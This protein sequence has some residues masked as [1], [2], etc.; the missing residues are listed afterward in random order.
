MI[1]DIPKEISPIIKES[2]TAL[3]FISYHTFLSSRSPLLG[4]G[5]S[6]R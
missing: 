2:S 3:Q 6:V 4:S 5:F 1:R